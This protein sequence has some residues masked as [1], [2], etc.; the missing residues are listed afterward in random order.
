MYA[1]PASSLLGPGPAPPYLLLLL[2]LKHL[3]TIPRETVLRNDSINCA[4]PRRARPAD[5]SLGG[6]SRG[7]GVIPADAIA[8]AAMA[9]MSW[10]AAAARGSI[11]LME[12]VD[13]GR[14]EVP[15]PSWSGGWNV[16]FCAVNI[17]FM[18]VARPMAVLLPGPLITGSLVAGEPPAP[19]L[20]AVVELCQML[21]ICV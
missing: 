17:L 9:A 6:G 12:G 11:L 2:S 8:E 19:P 16:P 5:T 3:I 21:K 15:G 18:L 14:E 4:V 13:E 20:I 10:A 1:R 7:G